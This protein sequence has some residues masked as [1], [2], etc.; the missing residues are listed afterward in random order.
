MSKD[1]KFSV[2]EWKRKLVEL[3]KEYEDDDPLYVTTKKGQSKKGSKYF[4]E[5]K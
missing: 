3:D 2:H 5:E 4:G 1:K